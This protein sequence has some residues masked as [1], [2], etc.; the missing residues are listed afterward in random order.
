[1]WV[2]RLVWVWHPY[3]SRGAAVMSIWWWMPGPAQIQDDGLV[4]Q[5][6]LSTGLQHK[7]HRT[8]VED[9]IVKTRVESYAQAH[10]A[11]PACAYYTLFVVHLFPSKLHASFLRSSVSFPSNPACPC[12]TA[13]G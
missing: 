4:H 7:L 12:Q 9:I 3:A 8:F 13:I 1:M 6:E 10:S 11:L 5:Q 2:V